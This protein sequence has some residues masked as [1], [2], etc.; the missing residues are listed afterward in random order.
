M[1]STI[2]PSV[3]D[4]FWPIASSVALGA[5]SAAASAA[6]TGSG[7]R[8]SSIRSMRSSAS[9]PSVSVPVLSMH[10]TSTRASPS[11]AGNSWT[12]TRCRARRTTAT[13]K[14]SEV[15]STRPS[16]TIATVPAT[17]PAM[18]DRHEPCAR[19]WLA[20]RSAAVGTIAQV[21][22]RRIRSIPLRSSERVR[23]N[24]RASWARRAAYDAPPTSV[25]RDRPVP[26]ATNEPLS[27]RSP[28][29]F[30]TAS[31]SPVSRDSSTS[32]PSAITTS[33]STTI[34][35]PGRSER[36]S[37]TTM[38]DGTSSRTVPSRTTSALGAVSRVRRSSVR[39]ARSSWTIPIKAFVTRTTPNKASWIGPTMRI[40]TSIA[41][42]RALNRVKTLARTIWATVR[43]GAAG[44][45]LI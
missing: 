12:S 22:Y 30:R 5:G 14:A 45:S 39:L 17:A 40:S 10:R 7:S 37:S 36:M 19:S 23:V 33:P 35:D 6:S 9:R 24:R 28:G 8:S 1:R 32:R 16:G 25:A 4:R 26:A 44:T 31:D 29:C 34:W 20:N 27:T 41:P 42:R 13:E 18:A 21:T 3:V 15:N 2:Q 11:T 38:L 43:V